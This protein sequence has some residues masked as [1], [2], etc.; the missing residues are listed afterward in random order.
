MCPRGLIIG[1]TELTKVGVGREDSPN[2][3]AAADCGLILGFL[4]IHACSFEIAVWTDGAPHTI[5]RSA[6]PDSPAH[7]GQSLSQ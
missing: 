3:N 6:I 5:K 7:R 1:D 4:N 2:S